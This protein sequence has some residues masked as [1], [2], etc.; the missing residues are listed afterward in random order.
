MKMLL[1]LPVITPLLLL[2]LCSPLAYA[3]SNISHKVSQYYFVK[4]NNYSDAS[5]DIYSP[6]YIP[7][8]GISGS[9]GLTNTGFTASFNFIRLI[10]PDLIGFA[11]L[12]VS[13]AGDEDEQETYDYYTGEKI[14]LNREKSMLLLPITIGVQQR[15]FRHDIEST[16]RPFVEI[17][18]G[19]TFGLISDY[20]D[21][22]FE[23]FTGAANWGVNGF[24]GVGAYFGSN[25][26][27]LQGITFRYQ[28]NYFAKSVEII[29]DTPR[30]FFGNISLNIVFGMFFFE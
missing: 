2:L 13:A 15:L 25:P 8:N 30:R 18:A 20:D 24:V 3:E 17:G 4:E 10:S 11:S 14:A 23:T 29:E 28:F 21:N 6:K 16:L 5:E 19:P 9:V 1:R 12:C 7:M 27:S 26:T 22:F